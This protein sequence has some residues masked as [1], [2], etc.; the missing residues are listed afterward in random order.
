MNEVLANLYG[1]TGNTNYLQPGR[2]VQPPGSHWIRWR[3]ART[4]SNGLHANTQIPKIIG[5]AR[6]YEFT[7]NPQYADHRQHFSGTPWRCTVPMSSAA[8]AT[9]SI[10][11]P[12]ND[13]AGILTPGHLRNLQHLQH[14]QAHARTCSSGRRP[15]QKWIFT[16]A[17]STT[18]SSRRRTRTRAC[19]FISCRSSPAHFKTYS[20]PENSFWC[21]VGTGME[22]HSRN[23]ATAI[24]FHGEDSL[25]VNLFIASELSW[26]DKGLVV[27]Q[28]TKFPEKRHDA[29]EFQAGSR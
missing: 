10:S 14:A 25:Y 16:S 9:A 24:Y 5:A 27:R 4:G 17:R 7:G 12:T 1:V 21:C 2:E 23:T 29:A 13:F 28:E 19:S 26:P 11:F 22:N 15:P 18:T 8:T 3:A 6:I 20:T